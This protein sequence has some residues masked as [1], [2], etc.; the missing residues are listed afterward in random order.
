MIQRTVSARPFVCALALAALMAAACAGPSAAPAGTPLQSRETPLPAKSAE[1]LESLDALLLRLSE[2]YFP[3]TAG[4]SLA[5]A[6]LAGTLLDWYAAED[7]DADDIAATV[8]ARRAALDPEAD[9]LFKAQIDGLR[10]AAAGMLEDNA[11]D[12]LAAAGYEPLYY[13][14]ASED[15]AALCAALSAGF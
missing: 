14:W 5:A 11:A 10:A 15:I 4:S 9:A 8:L 3:A 13:P 7:P 2:E 1:P 6:R 12:L